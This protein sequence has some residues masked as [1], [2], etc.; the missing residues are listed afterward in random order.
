MKPRLTSMWFYGARNSDRIAKR[1][2]EALGAFLSSGD[3]RLIERTK[4]AD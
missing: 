1:A 2:A 3:F 4:S